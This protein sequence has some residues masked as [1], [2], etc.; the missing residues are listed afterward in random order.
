MLTAF[1]AERS[2]A[3]RDVVSRLSAAVRVR[4]TLDT[5]DTV[6]TVDKAKHHGPM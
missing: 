6:D 3:Q 4:S 2:D 5:L 1:A